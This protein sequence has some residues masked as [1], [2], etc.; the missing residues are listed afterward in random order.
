[1]YGDVH[2]AEGANRHSQRGEYHAKR[3]ERRSY[4]V[5]RHHAPAY[6]E[7]AEEPGPPS[8]ADDDL[9]LD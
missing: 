2:D 5:Q 7:D 8:E 9:E 3:A 1:M 6:V 4:P